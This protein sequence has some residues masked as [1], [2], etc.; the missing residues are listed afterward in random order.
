MGS[1]LPLAIVM[2]GECYLFPV[3]LSTPLPIFFFVK[4]GPIYKIVPII[5]LE[6]GTTLG[7]NYYLPK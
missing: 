6:I 1:L 4:W 7:V 3:I 5:K 2:L